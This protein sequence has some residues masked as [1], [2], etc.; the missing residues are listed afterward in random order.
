MSELAK[1][2]DLITTT[3]KLP[4]LIKDFPPLVKPTPP[5]PAVTPDKPETPVAPEPR[6]PKPAQP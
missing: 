4:E 2:P 3:I 1:L 5:M 6:E